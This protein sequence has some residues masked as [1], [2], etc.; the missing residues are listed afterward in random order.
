[1]V[2]FSQIRREYYPFIYVIWL[3]CVN[4]MLAFVLVL[5]QRH[6]IISNNLYSI[7]EGLLL[8]WFFQELGVFRRWKFMRYLLS[9]LFVA[10]WITDNFIIHPF[11]TSFNSY[12]NIFSSFTLVLLAITTI[13]NILVTEKEVLKNPAFLICIAITIFFTYMILVESFW[14]YGFTQRKSSFAN[15]VY[16]ILSWINLFCNLIYA[17]AILWMRKKQDFTLQF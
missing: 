2:R 1:M 14:I 9:L 8:L 3:A 15:N 10:V 5:S 11:G 7:I 13:N 12:F 17:V 6:N 4:E 16:S